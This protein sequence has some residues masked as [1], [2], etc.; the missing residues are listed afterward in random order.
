MSI[1]QAFQSILAHKLRSFLTMLGIIIGIAALITIVATIQ[2]TNEQIKE[3]LIGA[4][5][6]LI[7]I[8]LYQDDMRYEMMYQGNPNGVTVADA[9]DKAALC[10]I[11][12]V[13]DVTFYRSRSYAEST[14]YQNTAFNGGLCGVDE[15]YFSVHGLQ[16]TRGRG[17]TER[18]FESVQKNI[19]IDKIA[20][21]GLFGS[22]DPVGKIIE[23]KGEPFTVIGVAQKSSRFEPV[24]N[25][26]EDYAL[27]A[28][29]EN[30]ML[31]LPS[32]AWPVIYRFDEP[33][34]V[35]VSASSTDEMTNVGREVS[36]YLN[37]NLIA[38]S[39]RKNGFS[40]RS[41][42]LLERA[43]K[44]QEMSNSTNQQLLWIALIALVVGGVGVMNIMLVSVTERTSEIGLR[45]A[46][47]A[48][49][50][51]ILVQFLTEAAVLTGIGG[52]LGVGFGVGLSALLEKLLETPISINIP[53]VVLA[54]GFSV[55]IGFLFGLLPAVKASKLNPIEALRRE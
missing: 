33:P 46:I 53:S 49:R 8:E 13:K 18:D 27:Y 6:N 29:D 39:V 24:I 43:E 42:D 22:E 19:I 21:R 10:A 3:N 16:I 17:F 23:I 55:V 15:S 37:E 12:N 28:S 32:N 20:A 1:S 41:N 38:E 30:G 7:T 2:G 52:V 9:E 50:S 54:V 31:Y 34:T 48:K 14:Y 51:K 36:D 35:T 47:G 25:S 5:N 26:P 11:D 45:K 4:G 40:Y 44:L